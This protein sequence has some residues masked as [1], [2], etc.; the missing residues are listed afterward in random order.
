MRFITTRTADHDNL[1]LLDLSVVCGVEKDNVGGCFIHLNY[2]A[3]FE[4]L[5][6]STSFE[7][8]RNALEEWERSK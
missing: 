2:N 6:I 5:G 7:V 3:A 1:Y 4:C 8:I